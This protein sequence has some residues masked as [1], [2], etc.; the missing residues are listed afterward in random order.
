MSMNEAAC[1]ELLLENKARL[2]RRVDSIYHDYG[3]IRRTWPNIRREFMDDCI[4]YLRKYTSAT[5]HGTAASFVTNP[6]V[7]G[8]S[9]DGVWYGAAV[10]LEYAEVDPAAPGSRPELCVV[11]TLIRGTLTA[12]WATVEQN[13]AV[14]VERYHYY[15]VH[16]APAL[17]AASV[18]VS[19]RMGP[20]SLDPVTKR[21]STYIDKLTRLEQNRFND[22]VGK[23]TLATV[24]RDTQLGWDSD[25]DIYNIGTAPQGLVYRRTIS[26]NDDCTTNS[27][28]DKELS[29]AKSVY[30]ASERT[31]FRSEDS[32]LYLNA[33][34]KLD[35]PTPAS[36]IYRVSQ[37]L[38][39]DGTYRGELVYRVGTN[40][41]EALFQSR[42]ATLSAEATG[43]YRNRSSQVVA[44]AAG[45]GGIY[46]AN[47]TLTEEG[48]YDAA[49]IYRQSKA[50]TVEFASS[51]ATL[52]NETSLLYRNAAA[53]VEAPAASVGTI[54][55][56][57]NAL[58]E[59]GTYD[60][61]LRTRTAAAAVFV[62]ASESS[63]VSN[64]A[65]RIYIN[66]SGIVEAP[67][68]TV[69]VYRANNTENEDGTYNA[70]LVYRAPSSAAAA[71]ASVASQGADETT[72]IY[73]NAGAAV[74]ASGAAVGVTARAANSLNNDGLYDA[75][76]QIR[77]AKALA[78]AFTSESGP[79]GTATTDIY[80]NAAAAA[81][82]P[83]AA[84]GIVYAARFRHNEDGTVDGS[85][86][87]RVSTAATAPF[88]SRSSPL[89]TGAAI[90]YRY[91]RSV[92]PAP[93][94]AA[95]GIYSADNSI[96]EDGTYN[97]NLVYEAGVNVGASW[98]SVYGP[99]ETV[100]EELQQ[101]ANTIPAAAATG[102]ET[103]R[104]R[105]SL[106]AFGLYDYRKTTATARLPSAS[107]ASYHLYG[108]SYT[109]KPKGGPTI[110]VTPC[111]THTMGWAA[112]KATAEAAIEGGYTGSGMG[113]SG[114]GIWWYHKVV[115][116]T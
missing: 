17:P 14:K 116:S 28:T 102:L 89:Q 90:L 67:T 58:N 74:A 83:A 51:T 15:D 95:G 75:S 69:G 85:M 43:I 62:F 72:V 5:N 44:P 32:A 99:D 41:G 53:K 111:F 113:Y 38:Q 20:V 4:E 66:R 39:E 47:N 96:A 71:H 52:E 26:K 64:E 60:A 87:A 50:E 8:K 19:Y 76:L 34:S 97:A 48:L 49:L 46:E 13:C 112:D 92:V 106:N 22:T 82:A 94:A 109:W 108:E 107:A 29:I 40:A 45:Q 98:T 70:S 30:F 103:Q 84:A 114:N 86:E 23:S 100:E 101:N 37:V 42:E 35:T 11:E 55:R 104:V 33:R 25:S 59:D 91:S 16:S 77:T 80:A 68:P 61:T 57:D 6:L 31:P 81:S 18:G 1:K 115:R 9:H 110:I 65:T 56:A 105:A 12:P 24:Y 54:A 3:V 79:L 63:P 10:A 2:V 93:A 73:R 21:Y 36:G 7:D 78:A 88:S 27:T